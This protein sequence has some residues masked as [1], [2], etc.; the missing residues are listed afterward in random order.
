[1]TVLI[2]THGKRLQYA[3]KGES[4]VTSQIRIYGAPPKLAV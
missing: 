4:K 1:L 2:M 3:P